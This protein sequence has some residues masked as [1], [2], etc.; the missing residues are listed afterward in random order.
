MAMAAREF[1]QKSNSK[2]LCLS[3][4]PNQKTKTLLRCVDWTSLRVVCS[5]P[6]QWHPDFEKNSKLVLIVFTYTH[7]QRPSP[8]DTL[9]ILGQGPPT[10]PL[11]G[12]IPLRGFASNSPRL[13]SAV[14]IPPRGSSRPSP[15]VKG[16]SGTGLGIGS[17]L[18][19]LI[20]RPAGS[21]RP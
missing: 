2:D 14:W 5:E 20:F 13:S 21:T 7:Q 15:A 17:P 6:G 10:N 8:T 16:G 9:R 19:L 18:P 1:V 3:W 11:S 4:S 12:L